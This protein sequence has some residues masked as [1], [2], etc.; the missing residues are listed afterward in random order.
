[1]TGQSDDEPILEEILVMI[2]VVVIKRVVGKIRKHWLGGARTG[3]ERLKCE[4]GRNV[5]DS[6]FRIGGEHA[7]A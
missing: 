2:L 6:V 5:R 7:P 3:L 1:M 4:V